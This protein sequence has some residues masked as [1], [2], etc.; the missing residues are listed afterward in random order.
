LTVVQILF[1]T[2]FSTQPVQSAAGKL[3]CSRIAL[4][5]AINTEIPWYRTRNFCLARLDTAPPSNII[6]D[7]ASWC[8]DNSQA[9]C[10]YYSFDG[11]AAWSS[12]EHVGLEQRSYCTP[13]TVTWMGD[14]LL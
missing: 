3:S 5:L 2:K 11:R 4:K 14:C 10:Y 12:D 1:C 7:M 9:Y 13:G 8:V 6:K